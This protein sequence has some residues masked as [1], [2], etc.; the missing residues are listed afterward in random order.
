MAKAILVDEAV[1]KNIGEI[2]EWVR[3]WVDYY[4]DDKPV[5]DDIEET[6]AQRLNR[7][8]PIVERFLNEPKNTLTYDV[9]FRDIE[10]LDTQ[11]VIYLRER[12]ARESVNPNYRFCVVDNNVSECWLTDDI[13]DAM[14][15]AHT[16]AVTNRR[17]YYVLKIDKDDDET[18]KTWIEGWYDYDGDYMESRYNREYLHFNFIAERVGE[19]MYKI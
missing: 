13:G 4:I 17:V 8:L 11:G 16:L 2:C 6:D 1:V 7:L 18:Y 10:P 9:P 15:K 12:K 19:D 3:A 14:Q 5:D